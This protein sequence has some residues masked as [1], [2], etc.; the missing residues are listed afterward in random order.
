MKKNLLLIA[1]LAVTISLSQ[2]Q[3]RPQRNPEEM[4]KRN[5]EMLDKRLSLTAD[6]KAKISGIL[7]SQS[8]AID[9]LRSIARAQS[10]PQSVRGKMQSLLQE[11]Q[12]KI[13]EVLTDEQ[14]KSY[15]TVI[16]EQQNRMRDGGQRRVRERS[17]N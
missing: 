17:A 2:A 5:L 16:T 12:Q 15:E 1:L 6:Q 4:A 13:K 9:S 11:N 14:R 10:A 7:L 8:K 3:Q